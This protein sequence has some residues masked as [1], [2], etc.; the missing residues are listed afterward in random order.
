MIMF[1]KDLIKLGNI[2]EGE[3]E[4]NKMRKLKARNRENQKR[5]MRFAKEQRTDPEK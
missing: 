1:L 2:R 4:K 3:R 5:E